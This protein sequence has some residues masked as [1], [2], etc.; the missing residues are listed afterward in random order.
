M[1]GLNNGPK[2]SNKPY[3]INKGKNKAAKR[4]TAT[5]VGNKS[6]N[7]NPPVSSE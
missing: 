3:S 7:T 6:L 5:N 1:I 4:N 2:N